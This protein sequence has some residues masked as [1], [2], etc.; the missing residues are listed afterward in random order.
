MNKDKVR[1]ILGLASPHHGASSNIVSTIP[2]CKC[3][4]LV[5]RALSTEGY[6]RL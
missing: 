1:N 5:D 3:Y 2:G 6:R 4:R